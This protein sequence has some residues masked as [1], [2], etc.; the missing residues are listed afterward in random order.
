MKIKCSLLIIAM[1]I[2]LTGPLNAQNN[3]GKFFEIISEDSLV[4]FFNDQY[5]YTEKKCCNYF[6]FTR[7]D[8]DG[9]FHGNFEDRNGEGM[10]IGKGIYINGKKH[11]DFEIYYQNGTIQ[12]K[13]KYIDNY[14]TGQWDFYYP[15]GLPERTVMVD[16]NETLLLRFYNE[17]GVLKVNDGIGEFSGPVGYELGSSN[18]ILAKGKIVNGRPEG[19]WVSTHLENMVFCKEV[20]E[21]GKF[22]RG[23][24]PNIINGENGTYRDK[25]FLNNFLTENYLISLETFYLNECK[26]ESEKP[27][28]YRSF[29]IDKFNSDLGHKIE[30]IIENDFSSGNT[31]DYLTGDNTLTIK[32]SIDDA[33][34]PYNFSMLTA[35]GHQYYNTAMNVIKTHASFPSGPKTMYFHLK[36][37][38]SG[39]YTYQ[40][41]FHFSEDSFSE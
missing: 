1:Y 30:V 38:I 3:A 20:F 18:N 22:I 4:F 33:G 5:R 31:E 6:R 40:Y 24:F 36:F 16:N 35:W 11:G 10:L 15:N 25:S 26:T 32:F 29:D 27:E 37:H 28:N 13:G 21:N 34:K 12:G 19:K 9:Y 17:K 14:P 23:S 8:T 7:I 41:G 39:G 2:F